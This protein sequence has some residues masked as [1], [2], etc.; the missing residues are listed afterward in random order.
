MDL[1]RLRTG[2][3]ISGAAGVMLA[4]TMFVPWY[5]GAG[6]AVPTPLGPLTWQNAWQAFS[7]VDLLL[8]VTIVAAIG[9]AV[10]AGTQTSVALPVAASVVVTALGIVAMVTVLY[11]LVDEPGVDPYKTIELGAYGGLVLCAAIAV[12]G[13][14]SMRDEGTSI[15]K[16][17]SE[18]ERRWATE[19]VPVEP[20]PRPGPPPP[21][22]R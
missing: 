12:G 15:S 3:L 11:R 7:V 22:A 18:L 1:Q 10:L 5:G 4:V 17:V 13:W 19:D 9:A 14:L 8:F 20:P 2:E 6:T 16:A 21:A